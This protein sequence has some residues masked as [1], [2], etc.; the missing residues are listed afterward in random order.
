M[1]KRYEG[2]MIR[3]A[4][5]AALWFTAICCLFTPGTFGAALNTGLTNAFGRGRYVLA[6]LLVWLIWILANRQCNITVWVY[7]TICCLFIGASLSVLQGDGY[8]NVLHGFAVMIAYY[9]GDSG[10]YFLTV[11]MVAVPFMHQYRASL[12]VFKKFYTNVIMPK[13]KQ[14]KFFVKNDD[15]GCGEYEPLQAVFDKHGIKATVENLKDGYTAIKYYIRLDPGTFYSKIKNL[16]ND[17]ALG[18]GKHDNDISIGTEGKLVTISV[19]KD[20]DK[21]Q[22]PTLLMLLNNLK[23]NKETLALPIGVDTNGEPIFADLFGKTHMLVA[24]GSGSG[25]SMCVFSFVLGLAWRNCPDTLEMILID[26]KECDLAVL[27]RLPHLIMDVVLDINKIKSAIDYIMTELKRRKRVKAQYPNVNFKPLLLLIDEIDEILRR[28]NDKRLME[29]LITLATQAR[30]SNILLILTSQRPDKDT[31]NKSASA[32]FLTRMCL[33]VESRIESDIILDNSKFNASKLNGNGDFYFK[34]SG[35]IVRGQGY[36]LTTENVLDIANNLAIKYMPCPRIPLISVDND[37]YT[38]IQRLPEWMENFCDDVENIMKPVSGNLYLLQTSP[39][40]LD[41]PDIEKPYETAAWTTPDSN[42][43]P[44]GRTA[45]QPETIENMTDEGINK[46]SGHPDTDNIIKRIINL[47]KQNL[48][49]REIA[50]QV[51]V[52]KST[53]GDIIKKYM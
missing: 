6:Y 34:S 43:S 9:I 44:D 16:H 47:R 40:T 8:G 39:D 51:G 49:I 21:K 7:T 25:K 29:H 2:Y 53:V 36:Y 20:W 23:A 33:T 15:Q 1:S 26:G 28:Q 46:S 3:V 5:F 4:I 48:S 14:I 12:N 30:S 13:L 19:N 42:G 41:T 52:G 24:G 18:L 32:M 31:I 10:L 35:K 11:S 45:G 37:N 38:D 17:I 22:S 27:N 50:A